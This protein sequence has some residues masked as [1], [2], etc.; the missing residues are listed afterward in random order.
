MLAHM[1]IYIHKYTYYT[2]TCIRLYIHSMYTHCTYT[3][4]HI[5][6]HMHVHIKTCAVLQCKSLSIEKTTLDLLHFLWW[7]RQEHFLEVWMMTGVQPCRFPN[8]EHYKDRD[9]LTMTRHNIAL[10]TV[11]YTCLHTCIYTYIIYVQHIHMHTCVHTHIHICMY[12]HVHIHT[13]IY[14][15]TCTCTLKYTLYCN[16]Q[17][18]K[19]PSLLLMAQAGGV[20]DD[21]GSST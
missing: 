9:E 5:C 15:Y 3:Y 10:V 20:L 1:Y 13:C 18:R 16:A 8:K 11:T 17:E 19:L 21:D 6:I 7:P 12:T 14:A 4:M 2:Y